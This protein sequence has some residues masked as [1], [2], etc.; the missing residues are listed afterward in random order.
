MARCSRSL[1]PA[2]AP[3]PHQ[4]DLLASNRLHGGYRD[5]RTVVGKDQVRI[6]VRVRVRANPNP[7]PDP[8]PEPEPEPEP[9]P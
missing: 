8:N 3:A 2:S 4:S 1:A 9:E 6:R 5:P 7:N